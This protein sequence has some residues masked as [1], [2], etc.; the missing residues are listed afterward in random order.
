VTDP[1]TFLLSASVRNEAMTGLNTQKNT[2]QQILT[3]FT[4]NEA[5]SVH[6]RNPILNIPAELMDTVKDEDI[7]E[8]H[9]TMA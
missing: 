9:R 4:Q 1:K 7:L 2:H 3:E 5:V 8:H 6:K